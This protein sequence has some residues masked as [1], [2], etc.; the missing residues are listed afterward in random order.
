MFLYISK[1]EAHGDVR[2]KLLTG[3]VPTEGEIT[4]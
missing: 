1:K 3:E 2:L 4:Q